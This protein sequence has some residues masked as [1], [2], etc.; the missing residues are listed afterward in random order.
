MRFGLSNRGPSVQYCRSFSGASCPD[1]GVPAPSPLEHRS[2]REGP[3]PWPWSPAGEAV[4]CVAV[5][6][7]LSGPQPWAPVGQLGPPVPPQVPGALAVLFPGGE[8][9]RVWGTFQDHDQ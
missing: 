5:C 6:G 8:T 9:P 3:R 4:G 1:L 2:L 7:H